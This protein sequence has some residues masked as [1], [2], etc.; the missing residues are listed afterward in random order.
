VETSQYRSVAQPLAFAPPLEEEVYSPVRL[1]EWEYNFGAQR[2]RQKVRFEDGRL[3][4]IEAL[5]YG[6]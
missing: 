1:E 2:F 3:R 4:D 5:G 6:D